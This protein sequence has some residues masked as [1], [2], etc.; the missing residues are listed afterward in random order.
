MEEE[1]SIKAAVLSWTLGRASGAFSNR[2]KSCMFLT[3]FSAVGTHQEEK[4]DIPFVP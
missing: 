2:V 4:N 1:Q 3:L